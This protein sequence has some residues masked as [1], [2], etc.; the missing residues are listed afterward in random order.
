M[1]FSSKK[2]I[3]EKQNRNTL[4]ELIYYPEKTI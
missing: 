4:I 1:T 3:T 2:N